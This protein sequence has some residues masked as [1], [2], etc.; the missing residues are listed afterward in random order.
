RSQG[1][2]WPPSRRRCRLPAEHRQPASACRSFEALYPFI[3]ALLVERHRVRGP[4]HTDEVG[5][6]FAFKD[7]SQQAAV[8]TNRCLGVGIERRKTIRPADIQRR[9]R[10][11][12]HV[13]LLDFGH[14]I[15]PLA[16]GRSK[17][18]FPTFDVL[19]CRAA[20]SLSEIKDDDLGIILIVPDWR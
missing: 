8:A 3:K 1:N 20:L 19:F 2:A 17:G 13:H 14:V 11:L 16:F 4:D 18:V 10:D 7:N 6:L 12:A 9:Y 15:D 5:P